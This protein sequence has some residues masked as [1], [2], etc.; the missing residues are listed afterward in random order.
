MTKQRLI[1]ALCNAP[2]NIDR[3]GVLVNF[4]MQDNISFKAITLLAMDLLFQIGI[5]I[6]RDNF[7]V[8]LI[9]FLQ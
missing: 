6:G 3:E 9:F 1:T 7:R 8:Q 5:Q 2:M 4:S